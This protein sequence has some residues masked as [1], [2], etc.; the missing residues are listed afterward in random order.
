MIAN[1]IHPFADMQ[2]SWQKQL[3]SISSDI[4]KGYSLVQP[5]LNL[6]ASQLTKIIDLSAF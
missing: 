1:V 6:V 4:F 3:A 2:Q 5:S